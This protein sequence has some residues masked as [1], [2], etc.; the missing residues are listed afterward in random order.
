MKFGARCTPLLPSIS[1]LTYKPTSDALHSSA[2]WRQWE[3]ARALHR[4]QE[5]GPSCMGGG[6]FLILGQRIERSQK[7]KNKI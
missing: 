1:Q 7:Y 6:V 2:R 4:V 5:A 3:D